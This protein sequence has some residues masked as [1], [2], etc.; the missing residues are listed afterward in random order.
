MTEY[1]QAKALFDQGDYVEAVKLFYKGAEAGD[2]AA[3]NGLGF[4]YE[5]GLGVVQDYAET[6]KWYRSA[7]EQGFA[8][9]QCNLGICY[10]NGQGEA[11]D[12]AE[13]R[14]WLKKAAEQGYAPAKEA[15]AKLGA[16]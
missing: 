11:Q 10:Y 4:C 12:Y 8:K 2:A 7:A 14:K 3:Q 1:E 13:A 5:N 16:N 6:V 15:L 9:A